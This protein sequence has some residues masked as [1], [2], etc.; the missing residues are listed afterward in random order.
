MLA[1]FSG[2]GVLRY[3]YLPEE[4][5]LDDEIADMRIT[6]SALSDGTLAQFY[7]TD[8][9]FDLAEAYDESFRAALSVV[10]YKGR[11]MRLGTGRWSE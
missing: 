7:F 8:K 3:A 2:K 5:E 11:P 6:A 4:A 1:D 10:R 9:V